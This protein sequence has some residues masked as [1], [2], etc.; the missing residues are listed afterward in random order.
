[1]SQKE[2]EI[3]AESPQ[4]ELSLIAKLEEEGD[5]AADYLE[6]LLDIVDRLGRRNP[7]LS[8]KIEDRRLN[9]LRVVL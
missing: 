5:I 2:K 3:S 4:E 8:F 9:S 1:M 6:A 7:R